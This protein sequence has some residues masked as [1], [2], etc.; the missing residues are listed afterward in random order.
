L[1]KPVIRISVWAIAIGMVIMILS[2]ATGNGLRKEIKNKIISFGGTVQILNYQPNPAYEQA[3]VQIKDSV[4]RLIKK[5]PR[6]KHLQPFGQKAGIIKHKDLFE[7]ALLKGVGANFKSQNFKPYLKQGVIPSFK[8]T[9]Y[10]DSIVL[11]QTLAQRLT[12]AL[13]DTLTMYFIRPNRPPLF[14]RFFIAG[15]FQT[16]FDE[17][18]QSL[19]LGD[20]NHVRRLNRWDSSQVGGYE[21]F[22]DSGGNMLEL[23]QQ[24][25]LLLPFEY[26]ALS[27]RQLNPQIFQWLDLFDLNILVILVIIIAVATVNMSIALLILIM[28][29]TQMIGLL[30]ALGGTNGSIQKIFLINA[31]YLITKGLLFGNLIGL[32][33]ALIQKH[34]GLIK[35]DSST[36]YVSKVSIDLN[37]L[38]LLSLNALTIGICLVCMLLPSFLITRIKPV[39]ALRFN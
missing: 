6:V 29:R 26:D 10:N 21:I 4:L 16:D 2:V 12:L 30:K 11:S 9:G 19:L 34:F 8:G 20:L 23:A 18:D 28:E 22:S 15:I 32:G 25:R 39:K 36:Y 35:L 24:I 38:H 17:I 5:D 31:G 37:I 27:A 14:R 13:A 33:I 7:G 1:S 3:P